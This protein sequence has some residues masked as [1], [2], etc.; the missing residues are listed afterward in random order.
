MQLFPDDPR[1]FDTPAE[2]SFDLF[3]CDGVDA[4]LEQLGQE[5]LDAPV[6]DDIPPMPP[7]LVHH[8]DA[9]LARHR[10]KIGL[11][12]WSRGF[13]RAAQR[14]AVVLVMLGLAFSAMYLSVEAFRTSVNNF[15]VNIT[16]DYVGF[17]AK[18][19]QAIPSA[20]IVYL[21][22]FIPEGF[23][24]TPIQTDDGST[25]VKYSDHNDWFIFKQLPIGGTGFHMAGDNETQ[26]IYI[27]DMEGQL[28]LFDEECFL[29]W[30]NE[31]TAFSIQGTI[32]SELALNIA[33][34]VYL[35]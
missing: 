21:P 35:K 6:N 13:S 26:V 17:R 5:L 8:L 18:P 33:E 3:L 25:A 16:E 19:S 34:S 28:S 22:E 32:D 14:V 9:I 29:L 7:E 12:K 2:R 24:A 27:N 1:E 15:F 30:H 4:Y 11:K 31:T 23:V 20:D 10:R